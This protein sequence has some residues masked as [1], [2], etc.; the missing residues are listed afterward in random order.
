MHNKSGMNCVPCS[1]ISYSSMIGRG[2]TQDKVKDPPR[3]S[4]ETPERQHQDQPTGLSGLSGPTRDHPPPI[5]HN[6]FRDSIAE[7]ISH[8]FCLVLTRKY[9]LDTPLVWG[10]RTSSAHA[11]ER[12]V[13]IDPFMLR[14][15]NPM[16]RHVG[17][18]LR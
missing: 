15:P 8:A 5:S 2:F 10:Y 18:S 3:D 14:H 1:F 4:P 6:T 12:G 13:A 9:R 17:V 7:G 16:V 11:R